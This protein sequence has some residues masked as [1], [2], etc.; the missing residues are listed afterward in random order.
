MVVRAGVYLFT[1]LTVAALVAGCAW[2]MRVRVLNIPEESDSFR[3]ARLPVAAGVALFGVLPPVFALA[4][5]A[6]G[7][8]LCWWEY[9]LAGVSVACGAVGAL[10]LDGSAI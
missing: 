5:L 4:G 3:E 7:V 8:R 1:A 6:A 10:A 2:G 9:M